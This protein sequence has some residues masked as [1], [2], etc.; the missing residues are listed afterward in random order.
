MFHNFDMEQ[1]Q[2][3]CSWSY[4]FLCPTKNTLW[5]VILK[6]THLFWTKRFL[7][8]VNVFSLFGYHH[9]SKKSM[10]LWTFEEIT[11]ESHLGRVWLKL[12]LLFWRGLWRGLCRMKGIN[13]FGFFISLLILYLNKIEYPLPKNACFVQSPGE[14]Y[15][16]R[17]MVK[18][19]IMTTVIRLNSIWVSRLNIY[20][21][22]PKARYILM[23]KRCWIYIL[24]ILQKHHIFTAFWKWK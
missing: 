2:F 17:C 5:K 3:C 10:A 13:V 16:T 18:K 6:L 23:K 14:I 4:L 11:L 19:K 15:A 22:E 21:S 1:G 8:E 9:P 7:K 12:A 24:H 20:S